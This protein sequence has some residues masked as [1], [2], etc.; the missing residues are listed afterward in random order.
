MYNRKNNNKSNKRNDPEGGQNPND[1]ME[2]NINEQTN[3]HLNILSNSIF[4]IKNIAGQIKSSMQEDESLLTD[5]EKGF[6]K[7][8]SALAQ[9]MSR[10]DKVLTSASSNVMCYL[11]L[12]VIMILAI[13]YKLTK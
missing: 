10:M 6:D 11:I 2:D 12:F 1:I 3:R 5:V 9:T 13:L 4:Q 7:N 8:R